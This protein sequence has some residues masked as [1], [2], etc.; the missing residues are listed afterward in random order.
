MKDLS[1]FCFGFGQVAKNFITKL[2]L[3]KIKVHLSVTSRDKIKEKKFNEINYNSFYFEDESF[4]SELIIK[5]KQAKHILISIP[6][7]L[8]ND[9]VLK[10]LVEEHFKETNSNLSREI[11]RNFDKEISNFVQICP[12]EMIDKLKNPISLKPIIKEVS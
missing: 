10:N 8:G 9:I 11:L 5:L 4:D 3:E 6:P 1:I 7:V 12:K 2:C